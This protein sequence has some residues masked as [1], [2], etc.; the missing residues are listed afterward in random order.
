MVF[1]P[2]FQAYAYIELSLPMVGV[3]RN[4]FSDW[5]WSRY[6]VR[7]AAMSIRARCGISHAVRY[8][9]AHL[10]RDPGEALHRA[11]GLAQRL[12]GLRVPHAEL[13][14]LGH[15]VGVDLEEL[16]AD[17]VSRL[18]RLETCGSMHSYTP[19][20][21]AMVAVGAMASSSELRM[22]VV[23]DPGAQRRPSAPAR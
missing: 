9:V 2:C 3:S 6:G 8:S 23:G 14:Q 11:V 10:R 13:L 20:I 5:L 16:A 1:R 7:A 12:T 17:S 22:P 21:E 4:R 19:A 18:K 15:Q